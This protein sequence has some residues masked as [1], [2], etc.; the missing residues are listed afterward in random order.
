MKSIIFSL[1]MMVPSMALATTDCHVIEYPD[2]FEAV[3]TGDEKQV[4]HDAIKNANGLSSSALQN[5]TSGK[6]G[7]T[8]DQAKK[9]SKTDAKTATSQEG[10]VQR[11]GRQQFQQ[12]LKAAKDMRSQIITEDLRNRPPV[13]FVPEPSP[14]NE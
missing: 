9:D 13:P 1:I 12:S 10:T 14:V 6:T 4:P 2:H 5:K 3:C 7:T 8:T 11:H